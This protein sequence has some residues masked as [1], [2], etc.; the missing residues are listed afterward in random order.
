MYEVVTLAKARVQAG[1]SH[2]HWMPALAGMTVTS[3]GYM[4]SEVG[5]G[6]IFANF[7]K[8]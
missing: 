1:I 4:H 6:R 7:Y 2:Q 8:P 3:N 5:I